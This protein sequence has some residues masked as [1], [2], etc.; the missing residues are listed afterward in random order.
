MASPWH[1]FRAHDRRPSVSPIR[2]ELVERLL[3]L[4]CLH[5]IGIA[6]E[7]RISPT[8]IDRIP[9]GLPQPSE[10]RLVDI[11]Q[12]GLLQAVSERVHI[13]L[14]VA[15]R[16]RDFSHIDQKFDGVRLQEVEKCIDRSR[17]VSNCPKG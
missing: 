12:A 4:F 17:R 8:G 14:R 5:V 16:A 9:C 6:A 10:A 7:A 3:E 15:P 2:D 13:E 11:F 1:G